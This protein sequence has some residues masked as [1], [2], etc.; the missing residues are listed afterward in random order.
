[1]LVAVAAHRAAAAGVSVRRNAI[2]DYLIE[3]NGFIRDALTRLGLTATPVGNAALKED[4]DHGAPLVL[5]RLAILAGD[6]GAYP[7]YA[8]YSHAA[9]SMGI[10][11][12]ALGAA[13]IADG[14]LR[15][16]DI[17][18]LPGGFAIWGLD[19][20]EQV[21]GVDAAVRNFLD[22]GGGIIASCGG[23]FYLSA[24]RPD[25]AHVID[26]KPRFTHEYLQTGAGI[27]NVVLTDE[28]LKRGL[29]D[30]MEMAYYHGPA[31]ENAG[32]NGTALAQFDAL[33]LPSRLFIDN[34]L[35]RDT[36]EAALKGK[37]AVLHADGSNGRAILF[38]PHPEMGDLLRKYISIDGYVRRY[39]PIRGKKTMMET[40]SFYTP[41]D[42]PAFRVIVNAIS[43]LMAEVPA[44]DPAGAHNVSPA[45]QAV[46]APVD[47]AALDRALSDAIAVTKTRLKIEELDKEFAQL[48]DGECN[49]LDELRSRLTSEWRLEAHTPLSAPLDAELAR[50]GREASDALANV[51]DVPIAACMAMIELPIRILEA[52]VRF[53][54]CDR[55]ILGTLA[56]AAVNDE[57]SKKVQG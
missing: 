30:R 7:Y 52:A 53:R 37:P 45:P 29:P 38:S 22:Q 35:Q 15:D 42:S 5:P 36:F 46:G 23:A 51:H 21:Q 34:P 16:I 11:L 3:E 18:F 8:Y 13:E 41:S 31:Y 24:G 39:L 50:L 47:L 12:K 49:R 40:I 9:L 44:A 1:M 4:T 19:R 56:H 48:L 17:L 57:A 55:V 33:S 2:G 14:A 6:G 25:W 20:S 27:V 28:R 54:A 43:M 10:N 32:S 26:S